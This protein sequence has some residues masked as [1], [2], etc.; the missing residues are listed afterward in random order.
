MYISSF[1]LVKKNENGNDVEKYFV[2]VFFEI[3]TAKM[4][5]NFRS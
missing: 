4:I 3:I 1:Q 5:I 2:V